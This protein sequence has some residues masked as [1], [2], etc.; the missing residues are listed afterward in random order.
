MLTKTAIE[1]YFIAEKQSGI[2][3]LCVGIIALAISL[4]FILSSNYQ[5]F[6]ISAFILIF[7]GILMIGFGYNQQAFSNTH[8]INMV[9]AFDMNPDVLKTDEIPR[10]ANKFNYFTVFKYFIILVGIAAVCMFFGAK[11]YEEF[12]FLFSSSITLF[13]LVLVL[14][15]F[16][17][18]QI[19][20]TNQYYQLLKQFVS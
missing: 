11:K 19:S 8:R 14:L 16:Y 7:F 9:Y 1:K 15:G 18:Y 4:Y 3:L 17:V 12:A 13:V 5:T 10:L 6:K 20:Y 2:L